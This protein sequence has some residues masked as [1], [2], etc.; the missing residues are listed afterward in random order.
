MFHA[1]GPE[2]ARSED[3]AG[4]N[5]VHADVRRKLGRELE[6]VAKKRGF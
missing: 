5:G 4:R 3:R 6:G 1:G 2:F